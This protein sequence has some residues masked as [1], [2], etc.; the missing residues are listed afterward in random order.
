MRKVL[1]VTGGAS[2]IGA[3]TARLASK[4]GFAVAINF[5][6]REGEAARMVE[7]IRGAGGSAM[8]I[9]GDC[10]NERDVESLFEAATSQ[11]GA[12]T[13]VVN[14]AGVELPTV[15]VATLTHGSS[16]LC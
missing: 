7:E 1:V 4:R 11:L 8:A 6:T 10:T 5:R 9:G 13:A 15:G 16:P 12:V 2:G 14:A 3:A